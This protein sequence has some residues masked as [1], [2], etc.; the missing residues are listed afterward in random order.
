MNKKRKN[1]KIQDNLFPWL[2]ETKK[3]KELIVWSTSTL[4]N[5]NISNSTGSTVWNYENKI[6][7]IKN[8]KKNNEIELVIEMT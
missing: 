8:K 5:L 4:K 6:S 1:Y 2:L 3:V 7:N